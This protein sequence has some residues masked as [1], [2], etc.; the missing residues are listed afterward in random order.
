MESIP[1]SHATPFGHRAS[2]VKE[3]VLCSGAGISLEAM[4]SVHQVRGA[5]EVLGR[6]PETWQHWLVGETFPETILQALDWEI[7]RAVRLRERAER[8]DG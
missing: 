1:S 3:P 6:N 4:R 8:T 2:K 5:L 7:G